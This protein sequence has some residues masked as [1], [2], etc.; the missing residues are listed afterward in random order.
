MKQMTYVGSCIG[1]TVKCAE[2]YTPRRHDALM[3]RRDGNAMTV[4]G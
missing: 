4:A 2:G 1:D 3:A